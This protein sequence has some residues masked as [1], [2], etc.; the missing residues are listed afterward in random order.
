MTVRGVPGQDHW[1]SCLAYREWAI[2]HPVDFQLIYGNPIPGYDAP[3]EITVPLAR[4]PFDGLF[5]PVP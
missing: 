2:A 4:R 5:P 1:R 3:A